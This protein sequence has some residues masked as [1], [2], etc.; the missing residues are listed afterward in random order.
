[1]KKI[2]RRALSILL[3]TVIALGATSPNLLFANTVDGSTTGDSITSTEVSVELTYSSFIEQLKTLEVYADEYV[4][5]NSS[6]NPKELVLNY[7]RT[8]VDK[9]ANSSGWEILAGKTKK[10]FIDYV[11]QRETLTGNVASGLRDLNLLNTPNGQEVEF[12]HMFGTMNIGI[13]NASSL[14]SSD[15]GGWAG[16][17][18]GLAPIC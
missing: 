17:L 4:K 10:A 14:T 6:E 18:G 7:V 5:I 16:G 1:M 2:H 13:F 12:G 11:A 8:G 15:F 3:T 9:Y